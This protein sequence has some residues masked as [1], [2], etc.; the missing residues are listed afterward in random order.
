VIER[1][2]EIDCLLSRIIN[3]TRKCLLLVIVVLASVPII[4]VTRRGSIRRVSAE[5]E[6]Q[7]SNRT[8]RARGLA[9]EFVRENYTL[10]AVI[11]SSRATR[12]LD[13]LYQTIQTRA[14]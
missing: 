12:G 1:S 9:D 14:T 13:D 7:N 3:S 5:F 2:R 8:A 6:S 10:S 11:L 4:H